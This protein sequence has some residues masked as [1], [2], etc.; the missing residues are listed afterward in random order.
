[1]TDVRSL[2]VLCHLSSLTNLLYLICTHLIS[3]NEK[4][5]GVRSGIAA[6]NL[7]SY[8]RRLYHQNAI[9]ALLEHMWWQ[10][11]VHHLVHI[12]TINDISILHF[13]NY[14]ILQNW[15][16][17]KM[18]MEDVFIPVV[19]TCSK[20]CEPITNVIAIPQHTVTLS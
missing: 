5:T 18:V 19:V 20:K 7:Q 16:I 12:Y 2:Q 10:V 1:M 14:V 3:N 13:W 6:P 4:S 9:A 11:E 8:G 17:R 15:F